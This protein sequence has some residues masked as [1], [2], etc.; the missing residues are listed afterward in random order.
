MNAQLKSKMTDHILN[1]L[2]DTYTIQGIQVTGQAVSWI[3]KG[4]Y[5]KGWKRLPKPAY[6][7]DMLEGLDFEVAEGRNNRNQRCRVVYL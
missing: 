1:M 4:L 2:Y 3:R 6:F 7:E 5:D